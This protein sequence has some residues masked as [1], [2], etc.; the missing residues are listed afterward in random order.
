MKN[1]VKLFNIFTIRNEALKEAYIYFDKKIRLLPKDKAGNI[2]ES[3]AGFADNDVDAFRH[4]YVSGVLTQ[5]FDVNTA[6]FAGI[7]N[8]VFSINGSNP[9]TSDAA[10]NMDYWNNAVGRKYGKKTSSRTELAKML[11]KAM[12]QGEMIINLTDPRQYKGDMSFKVDP[13]KPVV[14][15]SESDT[16][17]NELFVDMI[18]GTIMNREEFVSDIQSGKYPGYTVASIDNIVTPMSEVAGRTDNNLG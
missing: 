13:E 16:R 8:E 17:R 1:I 18:L 9:S 5:E 15:L 3:A 6:K 7:M 11:H 14:V 2:D 4:A 12:K 10:E